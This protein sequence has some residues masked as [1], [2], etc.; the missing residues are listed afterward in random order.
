MRANSRAT[1]GTHM[2]RA[3]GGTNL[4]AAAHRAALGASLLAGGLSALPASA[5][6]FYI[7]E[8]SS[9]GAGRAYSGEAAD[10][11]V[12]SIWWNPAAIAR[13]RHPQAYIGGQAILVD[14]QVNDRGSTIQRPG[15]AVAPVGGEPSQFKP[16][17]AGIVPSGAVAYP[18]GD[19]LAIG[20][21]ITS[22]F[23]FTNKYADASWTRY[24]AVKSRVTDANVE[25]LGALRVTDRLDL[26]LGLDA[27]YASATLTQALPNLSPL[28][29]D[30][31]QRLSGGGW[32]YGWD[33]GAQYHA[34]ER[35][36]LAASYRSKIG[37]TLSGDISVTG[38]L[39]PLAGGNL[40]A[41]GKATF[42]TPWIATLGARWQ[43]TDRLWLNAQVQRIGWSE[44][45]A[46]TVNLPG[47]TQVTP[48][49][50]RDTTT[51]AVG[52]D[53]AVAPDW[54]LRAGVQHDP[55]PT[56]DASR[57]TR[58]PDGD[59]WL[60]GLGA[61]HRVSARAT[62]DVNADYIAFADSRVN[63]DNVAFAGTPVATRTSLRGMVS[64]D[65][66]VLGAGF[67]WGF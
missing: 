30:A 19:R 20:L 35:L 15:Q 32:D 12:Q 21:S 14:A 29:P 50:Y 47:V 39:G 61:S 54:T 11:G 63:R 57:S 31:R 13:L 24:D 5:A 48:Q 37:H 64:G 44:F 2:P 8:Q 4:W 42:N 65:A 28:L 40:A 53:Y 49:D 45:R 9:L 6:G 26:A 56:P 52:L 66:V 60:F 34:D 1:L 46:I 16:L 41:N 18:L 62:I 58:V 27:Q 43:A 59:R 67:R 38:L 55:T 10:S 33:V 36:T 7:Q 51:V 25:V 22:P 17:Q 23:N 3:A